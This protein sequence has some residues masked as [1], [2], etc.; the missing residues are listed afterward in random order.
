MVD[1]FVSLMLSPAAFAALVAALYWVYPTAL[2]HGYK[3]FG[4]Y[5]Y[6]GLSRKFIE[7]G[8]INYCYFERLPSSQP[9]EGES[10]VNVLFVHGFSANKTMWIIMSKYLPKT[11]RLVM[12]DMPGHG[13]S[14]FNPGGDYSSQGMAA[15][16]DEFVDALELTNFHLV[17]V[18]MGSLVSAAYASRF[19]HK[20][21]SVCLMCIPVTHKLPNGV[22][23]P[24]F[25]E[26]ESGKIL[27]LPRTAEEFQEMLEL[28]LYNPSPYSFHHRFREAL[29][30]IQKSNYSYL[31]QIMSQLM[32]DEEGRQ[33]EAIRMFAENI[34]APT[35]VLWGENDK[36]C[37]PSGA[38]ITG[39]LI[40][41]S[42]VVLVEKC[43][44]AMT[45]DRPRK[46]A[47]LVKDF[48]EQVSPKCH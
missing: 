38:A 35:L 46:C 19:Q 20:V 27:I 43:G 5:L 47:K 11:W 4:G 2:L 31:E 25:K 48:V 10:P 21:Q 32:N 13:E 9:T 15:K 17:G 23:T 18:S 42:Q 33:A 34:H 1:L 30:D 26:L 8:D 24:F 45:L 16:L 37:H 3:R 29:V 14:S 41:H 39:E 12:V 22:M 28:V 40:K 44:H 6:A 36:I 7:V